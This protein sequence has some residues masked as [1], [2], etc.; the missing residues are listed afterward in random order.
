MKADQ[1]G[2][3]LL[4]AIIAMTIL[5]TSGLALFSWLSV[6]YDGLVRVEE[7]QARH[8][9]MDDLQAYFS[10]LNIKAETSQQMQVN[11]FDVSWQAKLVEPVQTGRGLMGG[12]SNFDLGLYD[13]DI[14][15]KRGQ[16][17]IG[18]YETKLVGYTKVRNLEHEN[19]F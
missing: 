8:Q 2:F 12:I 9:V 13:V 19:A 7:V 17:L 1:Q 6:T 5:A 18:E 10:T 4:E 15:I 14:T 3:T 16:R 11:G